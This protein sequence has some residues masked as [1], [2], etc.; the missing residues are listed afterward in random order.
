MVGNKVLDL[1]SQRLSD[2][3]NLDVG[4]NEYQ[5]PSEGMAEM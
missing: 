2:D 4:K 5:I 3:D 1:L